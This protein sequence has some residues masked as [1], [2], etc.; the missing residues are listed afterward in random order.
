MGLIMA[1]GSEHLPRRL[2]GENANQRRQGVL[3][4]L[5]E[6]TRRVGAIRD[7]SEAV[8]L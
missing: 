7:A 2:A 5:T 4:D 6:E 3:G 1:V 8:A